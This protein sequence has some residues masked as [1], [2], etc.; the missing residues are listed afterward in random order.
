MEAW[1]VWPC[2]VAPGRGVAWGRRKTAPYRYRPVS[3]T[4]MGVGPDGDVDTVSLGEDEAEAGVGNDTAPAPEATE[5]AAGGRG[6]PAAVSDGVGGPA[7]EADLHPGPR[8]KG[9]VAGLVSS[10]FGGSSRGAMRLHYDAE[11]DE[12]GAAAIELR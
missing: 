11:A 2:W 10:L 4:D 1:V 3:T 8:P 5:D 6:A 7:V 9:G 12:G